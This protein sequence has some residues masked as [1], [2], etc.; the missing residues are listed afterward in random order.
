[1]SVSPRRAALVRVIA[2]AC[3]A[4]LG[5]AEAATPLPDTIDRI[6]HAIVAV[7][8]NEPTRNPPF[9]FLGTGF[10]VGDGTYVATNNHVLPVATDDGKL[11]V[12]SVAVPLAGG[13]AV[14]RDAVIVARDAEHDIGVLKIGGPALVPLRFGD[15]TKVRE[16][17]TYAFTGFPIGNV[18]GLFPT[19]HRAVIS[20]ITP[21][22]LT[23]PTARTLDPAMVKRLRA[24]RYPI[25]QLDATAYPGNSGSPMFDI[26]T[27][28][29]VGV[30]NSTLVKAG[31]EA[32]LTQPS[33]ISYAIP[34]IWFAR[35]IE[36]VRAA[37]R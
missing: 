24:E 13:E 34:S 29:V 9:R 19:T 6:R 15:S 18:I 16:G 7:G 17:E 4:V 35:A 33:G 37:G 20:A 3:V 1:M 21:V 10:A 25:F 8:T 36:Q 11:E 26:E 2:A 5:G 23:Q 27:G 30:V 12:V 31:K 28:D 22:V 14:L 32:A